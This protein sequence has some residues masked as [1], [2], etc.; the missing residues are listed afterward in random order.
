MADTN[1]HQDSY[2]PANNSLSE[3]GSSPPSGGL[4][5]DEGNSGNGFLPPDAGDGG[6]S[7]LPPEAAEDAVDTA[8]SLADGAG[9][10]AG[11]A[12]AA[13]ETAATGGTNIPIRLAV[14]ALEKA[15]EGIGEMVDPSHKKKSHGFIT[16]IIGILIITTMLIGNMSKMKFLLPGG[17]TMYTDDQAYVL[18]Q[19]GKERDSRTGEEFQVEHKNP[20]VEVAKSFFSNIKSFFGFGKKKE[21]DT[22]ETAEAEKALPS[23][24]IG[25]RY[26]DGAKEY[27]EIIKT[28]LENARARADQQVESFIDAQYG[29]FCEEHTREHWE[30]AKSVDIYSDVNY[31]EIMCILNM[32][33]E[34]NYDNSNKDKLTQ[35]FQDPDKLKYLYRM[36]IGQGECDHGSYDEDGDWDE[37]LRD[38]GT[39]K[40]HK[41]YLK[42]LFDFAGVDPNAEYYAFDNYSGDLKKP[43][44]MEMLDQMEAM[45]RDYASL[46]SNDNGVSV[47]G[48]NTRTPFNGGFGDNDVSY[49]SYFSNLNYGGGSY[50]FSA[51][52]GLGDKQREVLT[53]LF[54]AMKQ[55]GYSDAMAAGACGNIQ[56]ESDFNPACVSSTGTFHGLVQWGNKRSSGYRWQKV[57]DY[58]VRHGTIDTSAEAQI[59]FICDVE[60]PEKKAA[61]SRY[62]AKYGSAGT[63]VSNVTDVNLAAEAWAV[64]VEGCVGGKDYAANGRRYQDLNKRKK[65][66]ADIL[67]NMTVSAGSN[68]GSPLNFNITADGTIV[69]SILSLGASRVGCSYEWG[70]KGPNTFD[71]SGFVYWVLNQAGISTDYRRAAA[72]GMNEIPGFLKIK[73]ISQGQPGDIMIETAWGHDSNTW[74]A[75]FVGPDN[76]FL[77]ASSGKHQVVFANRQGR[78]GHFYC[79]M[80]YIGSAAKG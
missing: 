79:Y 65:Y 72:W 33:K 71:C 48:P 1:D 40:Y 50:A 22:T 59:G 19:D 63:D 53:K 4:T 44:N 29:D 38:N 36:Y 75:G 35:L 58:A 17:V 14:K 52:S 62:L 15:Y 21:E 41:Y 77:N 30:A 80:R 34:Y 66:G 47:F 73:D 64:Y 67:S 13:G 26:Q 7:F 42:D 2:D 70:G 27:V 3:G 18:Q 49:D 8:G 31:A 6:D 43:T 24:D 61:M 12:E 55:A 9:A 46:G 60:I 54:N 74:H 51:L 5:G 11:A 37:D 76:T 25:N 56:Q 39:F 78:E 68:S 10:A 20:I 32:N 57:Q 23:Y 69:G 45:L 16:S 28:G